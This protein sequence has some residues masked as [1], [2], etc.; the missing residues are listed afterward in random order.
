MCVFM[1][2]DQHKLDHLSRYLNELFIPGTV[3][4]IFTKSVGSAFESDREVGRWYKKLAS[5]LHVFCF[6]FSKIRDS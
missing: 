3:P 5:G 1:V 4:N 2:S 6:M